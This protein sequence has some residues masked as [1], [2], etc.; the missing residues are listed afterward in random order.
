MVIC[1]KFWNY[2]MLRIEEAAISRD[3]RK[4]Q[5]RSRASGT[6]SRSAR[7]AAGRLPTSQCSRC[8]SSWCPSA[9]S[10]LRRRRCSRT[11]LRHSSGSWGRA[12]RRS[13]RCFRH[14][15]PLHGW[16]P[17]RHS[18]IEL[19]VNHHYFSLSANPSIARTTGVTFSAISYFLSIL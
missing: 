11:S 5:D 3:C 19:V 1:G 6:R 9:P 12:S 7:S 15:V 4:R 2:L 10:W 14:S 16:S 18:L 13:A 17:C 8:S